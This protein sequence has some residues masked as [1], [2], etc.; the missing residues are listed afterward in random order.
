MTIDITPSGDR[1]LVE[2]PVDE[3]EHKVGGL[4]VPQSVTPLAEVVVAAVGPGRVLDSGQ[5][6]EQDVKVG[7]T[8]LINRS[9]GQEVERGGRK[10]RLLNPYDILAVVGD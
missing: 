5:R 1:I 7:Q 9:V 2:A 6:A 4:I 10:Y 3:A 8:V